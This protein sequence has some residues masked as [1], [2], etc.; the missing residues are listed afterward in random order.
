VKT[1]TLKT[2]LIK[3]IT[4][5]ALCLAL[6]PLAQARYI[7]MGELDVAPAGRASGNSEWFIEYLRPGGQIQKQIRISNFDVKPKNIEIYASDTDTDDG[8]NFFV[9]TPQESGG[10]LAGWI[11]LPASRLTLA[12]GETRI[13]SVNILAPENAGVGLHTGAVMVRET[14]TAEDNL[15][16]EKGVRVYLNITGPVITSA[17]TKDLSL[18]RTA[19]QISLQVKT[20]NTGTTDYPAS[21]TL[22]AENLLGT[23]IDTSMAEASI[24]PGTTDVSTLSLPQPSFGLYNLILTSPDSTYSLGTILFLP[25]WTLLLL[26]CLPLIA[27]RKSLINLRL[28]RLSRLSAFPPAFSPATKKA[29]VYVAVLALMAGITV[30]TSN[31]DSSSGSASAIRPTVTNAYVLTVKWGNFRWGDAESNRPA[32][33]KTQS[34]NGK[35]SFSDARISISDYLHFENDDSAEITDYNTALLY[36]NTTGPDNDGIV[37]FVEPTTNKPPAVTY[38]NYDTGERYRFE[39]TNYLNVPG[40]YPYRNLGVYFKTALGPEHAVTALAE[41]LEATPEQEATPPPGAAVPELVNLFMEDLPATPEALADFVLSSDYVE[42]IA[43]ERKTTQVQADSILLN[44]LAATPDVL[45]EIAAT[46]DLNF[47]FIPDDTIMFP[48]QEFSFNDTKV[49][50]EDIGTMIFIQNKGT[51]W[52]TYVSTTDFTSL[53]GGY[54]IPASSLTIIPGEPILLIKDGASVQPGN[55]RTFKGTADKSVLVDVEP[56]S[57]SK[58]MFIMNPVLQVRVPPG[59]RPGRYRGMLT[60][61]SL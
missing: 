41:E 18:S 37:L 30:L 28:L 36:R 19:G 17:E 56:E 24:K 8:R 25:L 22:R 40:I 61:T 47:I 2:G 59:T 38:E 54:V 5:A 44:A 12:A 46:P 11:R 49:S 35:I 43:T 51:P 32:P 48:P 1:K 33:R 42:T 29:A 23:E 21:Y 50:T 4:A 58:Q 14:G 57:D 10:D 6:S 13:L 52:N 31:F 27:T 26:L 16:I 34:W 55:A 20:T 45:A 9:K 7:N 39:I 53:S 3:I 15:S 60:V